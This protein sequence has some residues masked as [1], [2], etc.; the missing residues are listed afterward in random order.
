MRSQLIM[1][2]FGL[3]L[4]PACP[5]LDLQA[6]VQSACVSYSDVAVDP[7][8]Q[9]TGTIEKSFTVNDLDS[10]KQLADDG[11]QLS[12]ASGDVTS[13]TGISSFGFVK[14]ADVAVAS[15]DP[16]STL[17]TLEFSCSDCGGDTTELDFTPVTTGSAATVDAKPYFDSGSLIVTIGLTGMPPS[18]AWS[19]DVDVCVTGTASYEV[20]E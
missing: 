7:M 15:G 11:F 12:F 4:L 17:P 2:C 10:L 13:A 9:V 8:P 19:M 6:D 18:V 3:A 5:L 1:G 14:S 16:N 20:N